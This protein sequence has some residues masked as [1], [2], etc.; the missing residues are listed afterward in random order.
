MRRKDRELSSEEARESLQNGKY[1]VLSV[2][3]A[4]GYPYGVPLHY[5]IIDGNL[6]FH[7]T[8]EGGYKARSLEQNPK[9][10]F[11]VID[12]EDGIKSR[13]VILFGTAAC[14]PDKR[15][16]VLSGL[17]EKFVPEAAWAQAKE[18]IPYSIGK[19]SAYELKIE[20]LTAKLVDKPAGK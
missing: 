13:S 6:Y 18:G 5:V 1:G 17:I 8:R 20:C 7:S 15:E 12:T 3:G 19:I 16:A 9:I 11:T 10:S 2:I 14:V 4:D